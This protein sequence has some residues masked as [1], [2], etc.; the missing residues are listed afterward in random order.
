M[1][2]PAFAKVEV[3]IYSYSKNT[4]T[5]R[6]I[7]VGDLRTKFLEGN[8]RI[9]ISTPDGYQKIIDWFD[10]GEISMVSFNTD[11]KMATFAINHLIQKS[12]GAWTYV[13]NLKVGDFLLTKDGNEQV[14]Q[15]NPTVILD[16]YD[17]RIKH[18][19]HRFWADGFS[20]RN[21]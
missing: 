16:V 14:I 3:S 5:N 7:N 15:I 13:G 11:K 10:R 18:Q 8:N 19:N 4:K 21:S 17:F 2:V 6:N 12:D 9:E 20:S 1:A